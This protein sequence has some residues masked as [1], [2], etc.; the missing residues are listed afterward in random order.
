ML[1]L[2]GVIPEWLLSNFTQLT[3]LGLQDCGLSQSPLPHQITCLQELLWLNL[4]NNYELKG[5]FPIEFV[6]LMPKILTIHHF[7]TGFT[8]F[9]LII[10]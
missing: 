4:G 9:L 10:F 7:G 5:E 3:G 1:F 8:S 2:G 6:T